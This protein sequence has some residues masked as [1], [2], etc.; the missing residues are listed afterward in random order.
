[1]YRTNPKLNRE[2]FANAL[3]GFAL[4]LEQRHKIKEAL[5]VWKETKDL[6]QKCGIQAGVDEAENKLDS[7]L[8]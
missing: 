3:R 1:M 5:S 4:V 7:L 6:Y 8:Q 2:N